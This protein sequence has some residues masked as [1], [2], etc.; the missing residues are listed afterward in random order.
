MRPN[1]FGVAELH[2]D[3]RCTVKGSGGTISASDAHGITGYDV[4]VSDL[5]IENAWQEGIYATRKAHVSNVTVTNSG[6]HGMRIDGNATV[7]DSHVSGSGKDGIIA[8]RA[9]KISGS[10]VVGNGI[11][12]KCP[13]PRSCVDLFSGLRPKVVDTQCDTSGSGDGRAVNWG[14]CALD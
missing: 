10:T 4:T 6:G 14:V 11:G 1:K 13:Y 9:L 12:P 8:F 5:T 3:H 7:A 2:I